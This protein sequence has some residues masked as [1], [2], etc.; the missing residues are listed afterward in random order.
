MFVFSFENNIHKTGNTNHF[1]IRWKTNFNQYNYDTTLFCETLEISAKTNRN[2]RKLTLGEGNNTPVSLL[3]FFLSPILKGYLHYKTI[4]SQTV[5][6]ETHVKNF[7][8]SWKTYVPFSRYSSF[9]ILNHPTIYL[10]CDGMMSFSAW[11]RVYFW[12]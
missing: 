1:F 11:D 10:I 6:Y 8:T 7:F 12:L 5:S 4:T 3:F 9:R 2:F